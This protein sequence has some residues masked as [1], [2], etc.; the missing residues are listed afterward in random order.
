M[1]IPPG[2]VPGYTDLVVAGV[3][4]ESGHELGGVRENGLECST[5][6]APGR[7]SNKVRRILDGL[8]LGSTP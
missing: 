2:T 6:H 5:L 8:N 7:A 3:N 1:T 4:K